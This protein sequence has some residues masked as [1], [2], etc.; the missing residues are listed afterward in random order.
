MSC[1]DPDC[2]DNTLLTCT[3]TSPA[4]RQR[5]ATVIAS[6]KAE[7]LEKTE[8]P[9][10]F[11]YRFNGSDSMVDEL[12]DFIKTERQCCSFFTFG[13]SVKGDLSAAWLTL[14]GP[15]GAKEFIEKELEL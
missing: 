3:L 12:I 10:G 4:L 6:L 7:V 2:K 1:T 13:L 15:E 5:K 9:D 8:L 11:S 14:T